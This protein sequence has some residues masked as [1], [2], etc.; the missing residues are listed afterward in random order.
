MV[1]LF[2][3]TWNNR[4]NGLRPDLAQTIADIKPKHVRIPGGSNLQGSTIPNRF[5]WSATLGALE[6]RPGRPGYWG[7]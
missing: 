1:S 5:N 6:D 7:W 4:P 2:P 3:P